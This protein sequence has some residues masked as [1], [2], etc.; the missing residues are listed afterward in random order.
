MSS[1]QKMFKNSL[2]VDNFD[3]FKELK[4]LESI[5]LNVNQNITSWGG[6][7]YFLYL[8]SYANLKDNKQNKHKVEIIKIL[9]RLNIKY[10]DLELEIFNN[11]ENRLSL[12]PFQLNGHYNKKAYKEIANLISKL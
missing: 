7:F 1:R 6:E 3:G 2:N 11:H 12:F 8:P 5:L 10:F 9:S 4:I